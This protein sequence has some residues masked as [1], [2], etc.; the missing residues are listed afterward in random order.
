MP[1]TIRPDYQNCFQSGASAPL[2]GSMAL[3]AAAY[4]P[5]QR[6]REIG[7]VSAFTYAGLS[8]GPV[9]GGY[10]TLHFGWRHVFLLSVPIGIAAVA[11]CL[12]GMREMGR[13][14]QGETMD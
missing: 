11:M 6:A 7:L 14:A 13:N 3:V 12:F 9:V 2:A 10:V 4:P 5:E 1:A 8:V